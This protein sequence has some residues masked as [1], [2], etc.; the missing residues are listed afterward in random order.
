MGFERLLAKSRPK[1]LSE[2][3]PDSESMKLQVHLEDVY[4][5]AGQVL[6]ATGDEQLRALGLDPDRYRERFRRIVLLAAAVHDLGKANDHF[7]GMIH[8]TRD[9]RT[10]PQGLRHEWATLLLLQ[11][12]RDWFL[13]AI[14]GSEDDF[15]VLEWAVAGHHPAHDHASPPKDCPGGCGPTLELFA[16]HADFRVALAWLGEKFDLGLPPETSNSKR[17]LCRPDSVFDEIARWFR[18]A[19][20]RWDSMKNSPDARLV[21]AVKNCLIAADVAGSALPRVKPD[22]PERWG[23]ITTSFGAKPE[24]GDLQTIVNHRLKGGTPREFQ[25][26]VAASRDPVTFVKAGCGTGKTLA[27]YMWAAANYPTRRLYFC[28]PTTGTAT[29]GF[30]DYLF[31][32]EGELGGIGA[33]LFHSRRDVDF[34]IILTTGKD[35]KSDDADAAARLESLE[36]WSTPIVACTVDTVLGVVQ[37]NK[38]GLF[39]WPAL[40]QSA[41]V[42]DEI[43]AYDDRLFGAL[44]RFLRD[45]PGLPVLLMTASLPAARED[46]LRNLLEQ[47]GRKLRPIL[48]PAELEDRPRYRKAATTG[49]DPLPLVRETLAAGGKV[50]WVCNTVGRVMEA[51]DRAKEFGPLIYHSRFKYE[52][53][54]AR[55]K[56]VIDAFDP[57]KNSGKALAICSQVAEMSLDLSAAL[58]V[59]DLAPVPALIQRLGRLN[60]RAEVGSPT[61]PFVVIEPKN[62]LPYTSAH[63][64][65][66]RNWYAR[67]PDDGISQRHLANAWEQTG[68]HPPELV[69]SAWLDGGPATT[70]RELREA[71]PGITVL[72]AEDRPRVKAKPKDLP[73][74][75]L[76]MPPPPRSLNWQGWEKERGLPVAP[77]GTIDYDP[78]RGAQ[79]SK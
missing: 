74:L 47:L 31:E 78:M 44:L 35:I 12:L 24:P 75:V 64:D 21:P 54:V 59:T 58:V 4:R 19:Q 7:Q 70:V 67:L 76:P 33:K 6:D 42:F 41:F 28:Y 50:L 60:R 37:N 61:K 25:K 57:E 51:A 65:A 22:D 3:V 36:A 68:D 63:L 38:R 9:V 26:V 62:H 71:S 13:P 14:G 18:K 45:L 69:A 2:D 10:N 11:P 32:P 55:H 30:K 53:R 15:A 43:H 49:N 79:W 46:A 72:M 17:T 5:A 48:G 40:A 8:G 39:A 52:D 1:D 34:D 29:E 56:A 27:A 66:A 77:A 16:G 73:R 20:R 23:W